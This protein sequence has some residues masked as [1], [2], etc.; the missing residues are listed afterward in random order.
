MRSG[1]REELERR[2]RARKTPQRRAERARIVL[3]STD[4]LSRRAMARK[5]NCRTCMNRQRAVALDAISC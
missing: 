1:D 5:F 2:V 3:G 4:G